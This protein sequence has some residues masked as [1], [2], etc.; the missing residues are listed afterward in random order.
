MV[1]FVE[2]ESENDEG[3]EFKE[4]KCYRYMER[5]VDDSD[6]CISNWFISLS[7]VEL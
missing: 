6:G 4:S 2:S 5:E 1:N 7:K 3:N